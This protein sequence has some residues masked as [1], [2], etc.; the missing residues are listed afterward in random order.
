MNCFCLLE[1]SVV[2]SL[3][4]VARKSSK[5][6]TVLSFKKAII[7]LYFEF[8]SEPASIVPKDANILLRDFPRN[9][10][11]TDS[12]SSDDENVKKDSKHVRTIKSFLVGYNSTQAPEDQVHCGCVFKLLKAYYRGEFEEWGGLNDLSKTNAKAQKIMEHICQSLQV[13]YPE[14]AYWN[15]IVKKKVITRRTSSE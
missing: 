9:S 6:S 7:N 10:D 3:A 15:K 8:L 1:G 14:T 5:C 4:Q 2:E 11:V 13:S 12:D